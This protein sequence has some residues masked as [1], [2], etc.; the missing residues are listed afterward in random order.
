MNAVHLCKKGRKAERE[1]EEREG[2][3]S[4]WE[5]KDN[6]MASFVV[7]NPLFSLCCA[8][9]ALQ[10]PCEKEHHRRHGGIPPHQLVVG[11]SLLFSTHDLHIV[12]G[13]YQLKSFSDGGLVTGMCRAIDTVLCTSHNLGDGT[14]ETGITVRRCLLAL[15]NAEEIVARA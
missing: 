9:K 3:S 2:W 1:E 8:P 5:G 15:E 12:P 6:L 7:Y 14:M 10:K 4:K 11:I 13:T